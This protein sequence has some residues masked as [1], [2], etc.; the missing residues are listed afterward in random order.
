[1]VQTSVSQILEQILN[2]AVSML[3]AWGLM[4]IFAGEDELTRA[5]WGAVGSAVG[6]GVGVLIALAFMLMIY[7][8]NRKIIRRRI[9]RDR[10]RFAGNRRDFQDHSVYDNAGSAEYVC[11]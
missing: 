9:E 11:I 2:A 3:A 5:A 8:M 6:T 4:Q 7:H 10:S 1:M